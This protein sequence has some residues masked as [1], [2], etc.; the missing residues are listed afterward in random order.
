MADKIPKII[1][2]N[3]SFLFIGLLCSFRTLFAQDEV[4]KASRI[5]LPVTVDGKASEWALPLSLYDS[6]TKLFFGFSNDDKNMYVCF[7]SADEINQQKIMQA[8]MEV[9][10]STKGKHK[11]SIGLS[12]IHI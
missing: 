10:L 8:G 6:D 2:S 3:T 11:V 9:T 5:S 4:V 1:N 7:Q 12:L